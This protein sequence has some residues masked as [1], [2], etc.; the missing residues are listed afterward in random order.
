MTRIVVTGLGVITPIGNDVATFWH[1]LAAGVSG[2][3]SLSSDEYADCPVRVACEVKAF[4]PLYYMTSPR[5]EKASHA[6]QFALAAARQALADADLDIGTTVDSE[7]IG[8]VVNTGSASWAEVNTG[9]R[10]TNE[11]GEYGTNPFFFARTKTHALSDS[12]ASALDM[13]GPVLAS[14]LAGA[15]GCYALLE[16]ARLLQ[17]GKA[18]VMV[19]GGSESSIC[20][21]TLTGIGRMGA[22]MDWTDD[23]TKA[24]CPFDANRR[25][26]VIGEGAALMVL[27]SETHARQRG[28]PIYAELL[29]GSLTT[30]ACVT[31]ASNC[32]GEGPA[33]A[34]HGAMQDAGLSPS[35]VDV[36]FAHGSS[37]LAGDFAETEAIKAVFGRHAYRLPV[38]ATKSMVGH[39]MGAAG[40]TSALA[41]ILGMRFELVPPTINHT[42][43]DPDCDLDYVPNMARSLNYKTAMV[44]AFGFGG[45]NVVLLL[46][47]YDDEKRQEA[48]AS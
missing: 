38:T 28:A 26:F 41:A 48:N 35:D 8:I 27:E 31:D 13:K 33:R 47:R 9:A 12:V 4:D 2:A 21:T 46:G 20:R 37:T 36:M 6:T 34:I 39:T 23:P 16:A 40:A 5:A 32:S 11:H 15:N 22:L 29:G 25:G 3:N 10:P 42:T 14:T 7:R 19:A 1:A 43:P 24:S 30:D 17:Q 18:D 44:N 45:H